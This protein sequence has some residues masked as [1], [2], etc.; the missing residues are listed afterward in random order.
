MTQF[1]F[2]ILIKILFPWQPIL[3]IIVKIVE[4]NVPLAFQMGRFWNKIECF[5]YFYR[6]VHKKLVK[7]VFNT[8]LP[9]VTHIS[10][11]IEHRA[12]KGLTLEHPFPVLSHNIFFALD[13]WSDE[14]ESH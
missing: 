1:F 2:I 10:L 3:H 14:K 13:V 12:L 11:N 5:K 7:E 6:N 8:I 4:Q 9:K